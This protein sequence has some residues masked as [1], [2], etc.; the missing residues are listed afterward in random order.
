MK[1]RLLLLMI[2]SSLSAMHAEPQ[3]FAE[4]ISEEQAWENYK[5]EA[6]THLKS[7]EGWCTMEKASKMMDLILETKPKI[8]VEIGVFAGASVYPTACAL[9]YI[10]QGQIFGIDPWSN[11]ESVKAFEENDENY[12]WW[13][14]LDHEDIYRQYLGMINGYD[15]N[16][17]ATT[18]RTTSKAAVNYFPDE[19]IDI[20]HIDGNHSPMIA[21]EDAKMY[22]PKVKK[23]GYIWFDDA[24][25]HETTIAVA[26]LKEHCFLDEAGSVGTHVALFRKL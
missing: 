17:F 18:M 7:F 1:I 11:S 25:W 8:C 21:L 2:C 10:G 23:G 24:D 6:L 12:N 20:L 3:P 16:A 15:L 22:L 13:N 9:K 5:W 19:S 14:K 4:I 26:F